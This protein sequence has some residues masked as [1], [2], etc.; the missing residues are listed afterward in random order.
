MAIICPGRMT[1]THKQFLED[2]SHSMGDSILVVDAA[3]AELAYD[4]P[5]GRITL[6]TN[7][8]YILE[9]HKLL[10]MKKAETII[11]EVWEDKFES[12]RNTRY[13][14]DKLKWFNYKSDRRNTSGWSWTDVANYY[15]LLAQS[16]FS[17]SFDKWKLKVSVDSPS[18]PDYTA[19]RGFYNRTQ[20][21]EI[22]YS[23]SSIYKLP[24]TQIDNETVVYLHAP[25]RFSQYGCGY[26]WTKRKLNFMCEQM[27]DFARLGYRVCVSSLYSRWGV[28]IS[29]AGD[30]LDPALFTPYI[31][32]ELKAESRYGLNNLTEEIYYVSNL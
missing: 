13:A 30:L 24:T 12:G 21:R 4:S 11:R 26:V 27:E 8:K 23:R 14:Q 31:Y 10:S 9:L 17:Y 20:G 28:P 19:L 6:C 15:C 7:E 5:A 16:G 18:Q 22:H 25:I 32:R 2:F 3:A 1:T 29:G